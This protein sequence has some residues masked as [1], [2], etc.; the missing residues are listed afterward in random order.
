[1]KSRARTRFQKPRLHRSPLGRWVAAALAAFS[2]F[3]LAAATKPVM[4]HVMPWFV[5]EPHSSSWGWHWTMNFFDPD[6]LT[7]NNQRAIAS[8]YYPEIGP[9]DSA[10]PAVLEY[11]V[12][13]LKLAGADGVIVDW[14]GTDDYLDYGVNN[15]RTLALFHW[16]RRAGL[17]FSLCYED[18]TIKNEV[19][20]GFITAADAVGRAQQTM[21]YAETNFFND[22]SFL[23]LDGHPVLLNFG[24][25]YFTSSD[26]WVSI[27]S[28]L[29]AS[30]APAFF[31]EDNKLAAGAGAFDWP[32]MAET[33]TNH[34]ILSPA[35]LDSYLTQFEQT[36][37]SWSA[38]V[39]TAF[40]RFHD[41]YQQAGIRPS[42]GLLDDNNGA[43]FQSTLRRAM[44]NSS[45][46]VQ[47][48]TWND[49]GEGTIIEPTT[50]Y[51]QRDLGVLQNFRR[52]Y[53]A[54]GYSGT[55]N[56][57]AIALRLYHARRA[58]VGNAAANAALDRVFSDCVAGNLSDANAKLDGLEPKSPVLYHL[59]LT[60]SAAQ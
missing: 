20:G 46:V 39:S 7:T 26:N 48:A 22:P 32:P 27:F 28:V 35:Q 29:A 56:D 25:Q 31:T 17:K 18:A 45:S 60:N 37:A 50:Q 52:L 53:L 40:P 8:W 24:P 30:N 5:A 15:Q 11:Q 3:N 4:V 34:G 2:S 33:E 21:R 19:D 58:A 59:A 12:L 55:T 43:T 44:T 10:D 6:N 9:Y 42:Y 57:F 47:V 49:Y 13:L 23:R 54:P 41:I 1:M 38:Y 51:A 36:A 16:T 14:Y